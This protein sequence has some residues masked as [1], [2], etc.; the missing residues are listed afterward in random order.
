MRAL[1]SLG[2][3]EI[4]TA[5]LV[6]EERD[7]SLGIGAVHDRLG[8]RHERLHPQG[9]RKFVRPAVLVETD[10]RALRAVGHRVIMEAECLCRAHM[11]HHRGGERL[12]VATALDAGAA[13]HLDHRIAAR[14]AREDRIARVDVGR[15]IGPHLAA[16]APGLVADAKER[17]APRLVAPVALALLY[18]RRFRLVGGHVFDPLRHIARRHRSDIARDIGV[19]ADQFGKVEKLVRAELVGVDRVRP[20]HRHAGR[21]LRARPDPVAPVVDL[22]ETAAGPADHGDMDMAQRLDHV[23]TIAADVRDHALLA[24]PDAFVDAASEMLGELAVDVPGD[25]RTGC[26]EVDDHVGRNGRDLLSGRAAVLRG[27]CQRDQDAGERKT[28]PDHGRTTAQGETD[29]PGLAGR[30]AIMGGP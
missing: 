5:P 27:Q 8:P 10:R 29:W 14:R 7:L 16:A 19:R 9:E 25:D 4:P 28:G 12:E 22:A 21:S 30:A 1:G 6:D 18:Q 23:A 26:V 15:V 17:H 13:R 2:R 11:R 24:D 3:L 20:V